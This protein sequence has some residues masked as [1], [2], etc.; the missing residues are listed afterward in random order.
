MI[1][2]EEPLSLDRY[3]EILFSLIGA[4]TGGFDAT[5]TTI[6]LVGKDVKCKGALVTVLPRKSEALSPLPEFLL[7]VLMV[8]VENVEAAV[9]KDP[10]ST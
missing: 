8:D 5:T 6:W 4:L 2:S 1:V 7:R 10:R 3:L 9:V